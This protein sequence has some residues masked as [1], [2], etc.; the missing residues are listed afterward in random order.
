MRRWRRKRKTRSIRKRKRRK[1][2]RKKVGRGR[3]EKEQI[4]AK[5]Y[6]NKE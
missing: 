4:E 2:R 5:R 1:W 3:R 6:E